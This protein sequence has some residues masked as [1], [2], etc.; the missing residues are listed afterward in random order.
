MTFLTP[1]AAL[2]A[3][4][5]AVPVAAFVLTERRARRVRR[6]LRIAAPGRRALLPV[7]IALVLLPCL[8]AVAAAQPVVIRQQHVAQRADAQ[9]FVL[10]DTSLSMR[11]AA[12]PGQPTRLQRAKALAIKL[13]AAMP[14]V[15]F[16]VASMTDRS[17]PNLMPTVDRTTFDRT[18]EQSVA[19][20]RPPPSQ[21]HKGR[22]TTFDAI[23]PL[24]QSN[25]YS[26]GVQRRLLV[27][28]TDGESAKLS[29]VTK[30]TL[31]RR[32][33]PIYVHVWS[34]T[35]RI[36]KR[37][38]RADPHYVADGESVSALVN[39]A[40]VTRGQLYDEHQLGKIER[41]SRA[42][43]GSAQAHTVVSAYSRVPL[44]PW[45]VLGALVP[46]AFLLYRRNV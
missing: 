12:G 35:E 44:A 33:T 19:V 9:V 18:V 39:L 21:P 25:F 45:F 27:V 3:L 17:L 28:F 6:L 14:D 4:V 26:P 36:Y 10:F 24:V 5:A 22:A 31:Q 38:G 16:G 34:P 23:V 32:V 46:L 13:E 40:Q 15:P 2:F 8:V 43:I 20:D 11:A 29:P 30:L 7:A 41:A 42:T 1:L 37:N